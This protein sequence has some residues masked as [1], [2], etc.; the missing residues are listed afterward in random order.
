MDVSMAGFGLSGEP[1]P[2][3]EMAGFG[4]SGAAMLYRL[5][6]FPPLSGRD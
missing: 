1:G 2:A 3:V 6:H 4:N 5:R